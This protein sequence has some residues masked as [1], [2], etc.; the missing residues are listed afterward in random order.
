MPEGHEHLSDDEKH[1]AKLGYVQE[2]SRSWSGFSNFA[3]SFSI[4]SILAGCF[5]SFGLGWNNGGPGRDRMGLADRL[6]LH[7]DHR[8]VHVRTGVGVPDVGRNLLV[9]KQTRRRQGR[10]LHRLAEPDRLDRHPGVGRL[11]LRDVPGPDARH[12][13]RGLARRLQPDPD[14]HSVRDHPGGV[15]DHQ[16]LLVAPARR[17][18]QR[19]GVVAR[20]RRGRGGPDPDLHPRAARQFLRC[21]RPDHQQHRHVRRRKGLWLADLRAADRGDP[22]PVHDHRLRRVRAPVGGD[23]ERRRRRGQ[24]HLAL[25]LLLGDRRLDPAAGVPLRG[26]GPRRGVRRAA[27]RW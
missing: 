27:V 12:I 25:D 10:L 3:I 26:A 5:T 11:R 23:Q 22:D 24:G 4:I 1:L 15:G 9:G 13:Q 8:A 19:L 17:H 6:G 14:V 7:P 2:L 21:L 16:H 20:G 18:Q